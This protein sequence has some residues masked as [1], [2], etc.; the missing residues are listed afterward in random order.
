MALFSK[1][2]NKL[3]GG[4]SLSAA[5]WQELERS[6]IEADR[7]AALTGKILETARKVG[8]SA[9]ESVAKILRESLSTANRAIARHPDRP[10]FQQKPH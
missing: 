6:L 9:E 10:G 7:G 4:A 1:L 5:D 2:F 3:R 8:E